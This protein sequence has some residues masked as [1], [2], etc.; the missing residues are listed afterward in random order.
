MNDKS[1]LAVR[2]VLNAGARI[3]SMEFNT[4]FLEK[5]GIRPESVS[6]VVGLRFKMI[7]VLM[8]MIDHTQGFEI[9]TKFVFRY[10]EAARTGLFF[11]QLFETKLAIELDAMNK[12]G[13]CVPMLGSGWIE[14]PDNFFLLFSNLERTV[15]IQGVNCNKAVVVNILGAEPPVEQ[16][17]YL[18]D[19]LQQR[20]L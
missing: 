14:G 9:P 7:A 8:W 4:R 13:V 20:L 11:T 3:I 6:D 15:G 1:L 17:M 16:S 19:I 5:R 18:T 10:G 2:A 12:E